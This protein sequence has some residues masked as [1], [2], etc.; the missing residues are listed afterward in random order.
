MKNHYPLPRIDDLFHQL[1]GSSVYSKIGLRSGY[2]QLRVREEDISK[3]AFRTWYD[4]YE[5]QVMPFGLTNAPAVFMDLMNRVCKPYLDKF[6]IVF[7]DDILIYSKSKQEH[8]EHLKLILKFLKKEELLGA[9]LMQNEK[10]IAYASCQLKIHEKNY[11]THDLELGAVV[12]ALKIWRHYLYGTKCNVFTDH[13]SLQ[14]ILDQKELNMRQR[15]C[16]KERIKPLRVRALVM[17]IGLDLPKKILEAQIEAMKLEKIEAED[18]GG[19]TRKDLPKEKLEPRADETLCL[20]NRSWL[21]CYGDLRTLIMHESHK[22]KYS[23]HPGSDKMYQ[24]MKKLYW[25]PNMKANIDTY[26]SK[27]L[28]CLKVKAEHQKPSGLLVQPEIPQWKWDNITM[29]FVTKLPRTSSGYDTIWVIVDRLIKSAHFLPMREN[30]SMDK[31][32]RLYLKEVVTRHGILVSVIYD[33]D[34]RFTSNFWRA[35]QKTLGTRLDMSPAYH[36][37]TDGQSKRTIQ[38]LEDIYHTCIKAAPFKALYGQKC[39]SPVCWA[40]SRIQA[41]RDCQKSY[42]DVR[43]KPLEFQVGDKVMLKV[44]PWKRVIRFGKR[45]KLNP[46]YIGPFK[47]LAKK[48]LSDEPLEILLD[49]IHIDDKLH[50]V[51]E[52]VE[53]MDCEVKQLKQIRISII[54][55][56]WNSRRGPEFTWE[57]EDQF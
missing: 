45:G 57:R 36:S 38:T 29:D 43:R 25:W 50:F 30:D 41:A 35:F 51:E 28:T 37:Q 10:V 39:R 33:R 11:T 14:H 21:P 13:K 22:L 53:I 52:P 7:I 27:C 17:T 55:V 26:V 23:V 49:E 3:T 5:F 9:A 8:E 40:E 42:A 15:R 31:L 19:M 47:V 2:H 32:A 54:K 1:Q 24:D 34:G 12:F 20:N 16:R 44:S 6:V 46:R 56:R 18:V 4:H 48:C